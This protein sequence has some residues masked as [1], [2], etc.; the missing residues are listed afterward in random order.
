MSLP[1]SSVTIFAQVLIAST[2]G[3]LAPSMSWRWV[4]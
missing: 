3:W 1:G 2:L 4:A